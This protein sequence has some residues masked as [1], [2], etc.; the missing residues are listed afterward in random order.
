MLGIK[1][2]TV[3]LDPTRNLERYLVHRPRARAYLLFM[4]VITMVAALS[5]VL[6]RPVLVQGLQLP[7]LTASMGLG[8]VGLV[9]F[10]VTLRSYH[11]AD[12]L[13]IDVVRRQGQNLQLKMG[14]QPDVFQI[15]QLNLNQL[16]EYYTINKSQARKSFNFSVVAIA[17]GL[18]TI[19]AGVWLIYSKK[20]GISVGTISAVSGLLLQFFG[21]A[22][23]YIYNKSLN[24]MNYFYDRLMQ[25]QDAMLSI[26]VGD[27]IGDSTLKDKVKQHIVSQLLLKPSTMATHP[28]VAK[29]GQTRRSQ[30]GKTTA[31]ASMPL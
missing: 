24:Q 29:T 23:F 6:S 21:G 15:V 28:S 25:M 4:S 3:R 7:A 20:L 18:V 1:F 31:S 5:L 2:R 13:E 10:S 26:K 16:T 8:F 9:L 27:Q 14:E 19:V 12:Y 22:N 11:L 17:A 30:T